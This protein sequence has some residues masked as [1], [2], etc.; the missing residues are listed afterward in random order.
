[1]RYR[2]HS[3]EARGARFAEEIARFELEQARAALMRTT[4]HP[5]AP[6]GLKKAS[7]GSVSTESTF[8]SS[9]TPTTTT[10]M[11]FRARIAHWIDCGGRAP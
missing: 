7:I 11:R 5:D 9:M 3:E 4:P 8:S 6:N 10:T 1:M 2:M